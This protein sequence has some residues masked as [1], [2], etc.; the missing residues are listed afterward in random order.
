M[1]AGAALITLSLLLATSYYVGFVRGRTL[2]TLEHLEYKYKI[3]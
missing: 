2:A 3:R 1:V